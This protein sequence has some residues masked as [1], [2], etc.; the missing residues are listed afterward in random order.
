MFLNNKIMKTKTIKLFNFSELPKEAKEK[1]LN[2]NRDYNVDGDWSSWLLDDWEERLN[3]MGFDN[4][5]IYFNGFYSQGDG[6]CF[7]ASID[8]GGMTKFLKAKKLLNKFKAI[9]KALKNNTLYVNIKIEHK[10][11]YYHEYMTDLIDYTEMQDNTELTGALAKEWE[12]LITLI[13][14]RVYNKTDLSKNCG[15]GILIELNRAIYKTLEKE[16]AYLTSDEGLT[17]YFTEA[18]PDTLFTIDGV[19]EN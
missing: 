10:G 14:D 3:K 6:A 1:A 16:N 13:D 15:A 9:S 7:E 2:N 19:I 18:N 8:N 5:K 4:V 17:E 11:R 12:Q